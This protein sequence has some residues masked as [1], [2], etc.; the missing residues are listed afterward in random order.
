[1]AERFV[2][3]P[4]KR[5]QLVLPFLP[6]PLWEKGMGMRIYEMESIL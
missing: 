4:G 1:M 5:S 6:S 2:T 3:K